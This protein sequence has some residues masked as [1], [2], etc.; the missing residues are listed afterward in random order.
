MTKTFNN[1]LFFQLLIL[2]PMMSG[3]VEKCKIYIY[4]EFD[5]KIF[6]NSLSDDEYKEIMSRQ[7]EVFSINVITHE[8]ILKLK[9]RG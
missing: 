2:A 7:A 1:Y 4:D 6:L 9:K 3:N 5:K 8:V